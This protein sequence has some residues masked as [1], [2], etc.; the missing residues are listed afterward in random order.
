MVY[1]RNQYFSTPDNDN[2]PYSTYHCAEIRRSG[3]WYGD[4]INSFIA[5][6]VTLTLPTMEPV[7]IILLLIGI[8]FPGAIASC[9]AISK[10]DLCDFINLS[11]ASII[12][13]RQL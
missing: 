3:W 7:I 10:Y 1:H 8:I 6:I 9:T 13:S 2:D 12:S 5:I 4:D 11:K